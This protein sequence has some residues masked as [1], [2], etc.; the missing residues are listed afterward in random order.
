VHPDGSTPVEVPKRVWRLRVKTAYKYPQDKLDT[1]GDIDWLFKDN[2]RVL[3]YRTRPSFHRD[4]IIKYNPE[5]HPKEIKKSIQSWRNCP[6]DM[7]LIIQEIINKF[8]DIFAEEG[9][10]KPIRGF[11]F[12]MDTGT[13]LH[14]YCKPPR[15]G[16]HE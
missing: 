11:K 1:S 8:Y 4:N 3:K 10:Q 12:N 5:L 16:P 15:Y 2:G 9:M 14:I 7:Q 13:I 6:M